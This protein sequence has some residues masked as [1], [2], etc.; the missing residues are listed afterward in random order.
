MK[1]KSVL[2]EVDES[3]KEQVIQT[4]QLLLQAGLVMKYKKRSFIFEN[5][6]VYNQ[7]WIRNNN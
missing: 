2:I 5:T 4:N 1:V 7:I 3:F 6:K